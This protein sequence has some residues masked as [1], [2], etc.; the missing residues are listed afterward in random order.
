VKLPEG[1]QRYLVA[2]CPEHGQR[3]SGYRQC[4]AG[5]VGA[6]LGCSTDT[7]VVETIALRD[8]PAILDDLE[9]RLGALERFDP[10]HDETHHQDFALGNDPI[11][12]EPWHEGDWLRRADVLAAID[13]A[14]KE[15]EG[16]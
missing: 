8:L 12:M 14:L 6:N 2:V 4:A 10:E 1:V 9:K 11:V 15:G 16:S 5:R 7:E 13:S 3:A